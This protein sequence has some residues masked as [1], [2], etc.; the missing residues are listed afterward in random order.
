VTL[1]WQFESSALFKVVRPPRDA[2]APDAV[3]AT[4]SKVVPE[5]E[6]ILPVEQ[7]GF[8]SPLHTS[9]P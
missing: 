4:T 3:A 9:A 7:V 1:L 2:D 8:V 5:L 6:V